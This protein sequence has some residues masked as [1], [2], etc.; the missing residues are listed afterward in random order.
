MIDGLRSSL[1]MFATGLVRS[2]SSLRENWGVGLLSVVLAVALWVFVTDKEHP[3]VTGTIPGTIA[4][5]VVNVPAD[6]AVFSVSPTSV[7]V[8]VEAPE[9]VFDDL[10]PDDFTA[11]VDLAN[12]TSQQAVV[13]VR[14]ESTSGRVAVIETSPAA[15]TVRL[16][17]VTSRAVPVETNLT[18]APPPGFGVGTTTVQPAEAVV[19]GPE[20]LVARVSTIEVD[21]NLTGIRTDFQETLILQAR[22]AT[23]AAVQGVNIEPESVV[24]TIEL[25]QLALRAEFVVIP[26]ISGSPAPGFVVTGLE[27]TPPFVVITGPFEV[28]QSLDPSAGIRTERISIN[29]ASGDVVRPVAL[30]LPSGATVEQVQTVTVRIIIQPFGAATP[31]SGDP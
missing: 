13:P 30:V 17:N 23:G 16:E 24:A 22:D 6:Q 14:V 29:G 28:F 5:T 31:T 27:V 11:S 3:D 7:R 18:G 12:V 26:D 15:V 4:V 20:S 19:R 25:E 10:Q 2:V 1:G 8:R 21:V 9:S